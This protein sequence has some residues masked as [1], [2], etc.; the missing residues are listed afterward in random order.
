MAA[1]ELC[2]KR[3]R[4]GKRGRKGERFGGWSENRS[5]DKAGEFKDRPKQSGTGWS[6]RIGGVER[7]CKR[8]VQCAGF[9]CKARTDTV[10][11]MALDPGTLLLPVDSINRLNGGNGE[12][13]SRRQT[14]RDGAQTQVSKWTRRFIHSFYYIGIDEGLISVE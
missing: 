5:N 9:L 12:P 13:K 4:A 3:R 7:F 14:Q 11:R 10:P 1:S 2:G 8:R 6:G